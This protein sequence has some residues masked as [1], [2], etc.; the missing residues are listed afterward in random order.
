MKLQQVNEYNRACEMRNAYIQVFTLGN[1]SMADE[2]RK[3]GW[4]VS[5]YN[6]QDSHHFFKSKIKALEFMENNIV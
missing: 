5:G 4:V 6:G 3:Y 2:P 1:G